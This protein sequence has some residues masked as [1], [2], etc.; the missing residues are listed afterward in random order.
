MSNKQENW[1]H[2]CYE[3]EWEAKTAFENYVDECHQPYKIFGDEVFASEILK[4]MPI[5]Y[6]S[7]FIDWLDQEEERYDESQKEAC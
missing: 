7:Y 4:E 5:D 6:H 1:F 3:T 2:P